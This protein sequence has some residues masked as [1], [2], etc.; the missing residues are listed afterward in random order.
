[1]ERET[2]VIHQTQREGALQTTHNTKH[3]QVGVEPHKK[4]NLKAFEGYVYKATGFG[5]K[6][7]MQV[8]NIPPIFL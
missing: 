6:A 3:M 8:C 7:V 5:K 1:M 2:R 4:K